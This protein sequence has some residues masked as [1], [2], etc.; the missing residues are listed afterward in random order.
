MGRSKFEV[1]DWVRWEDDPN[2]W[3]SIWKLEGKHF[4][5]PEEISCRLVLVRKGVRSNAKGKDKG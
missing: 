4:P 2:N 5:M 1:G 3:Q